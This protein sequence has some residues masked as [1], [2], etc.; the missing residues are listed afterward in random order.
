M[1]RQ[2]IKENVQDLGCNAQIKRKYLREITVGVDRSANCY[3]S[4][5]PIPSTNNSVPTDMI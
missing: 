2:K 4:K 5:G 3:V 1:S